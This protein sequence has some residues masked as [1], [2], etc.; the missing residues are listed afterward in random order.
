MYEKQDG[1]AYQPEN[2]PTLQPQDP[3]AAIAASRRDEL[4]RQFQ[5]QVRAAGSG[6]NWLYWIAG[7][8]VVNTVITLFHGK[9]TFVV[10]LGITR[11][12][13][14]VVAQFGNTAA[15]VAAPVSFFFAGIYVAL[16]YCACRRMRWAFITGIVLYSLDTLIVLSIKDWFSVAFHAF[17]LYCM[18]AGLSAA[19]KAAQTEEQLRQMA[20]DR[21]A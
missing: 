18:F 12:M 4:S 19:T 5:E 9:I 14:A 6:G 11:I 10:G 8:S 15:I 17:A 3:R 1:P 16:G 2:S 7:L 21:A 20:V 13:D